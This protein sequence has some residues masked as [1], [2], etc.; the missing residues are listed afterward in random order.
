MQHAE[1]C[2]GVLV[3]MLEGKKSRRR[4]DSKIDIK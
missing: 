2:T 4:A 1:M 3:G